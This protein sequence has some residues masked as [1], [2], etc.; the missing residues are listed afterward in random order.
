MNEY[1]DKEMEKLER[2]QR[3]LKKRKDEDNFDRYNE[4]SKFQVEDFSGIVESKVKFSPQEGGL[5]VEYATQVKTYAEINSEINWKTHV[6]NDKKI[7]YTHKLPL[8][9]FMCNDTKLITVL[10]R[11]IGLMASRH[12]QD[13]F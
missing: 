11:V 7:W 10:V 5:W 8:G 9:C 6:D 4:V 12:P 2:Q 3:E 1:Y 13:R